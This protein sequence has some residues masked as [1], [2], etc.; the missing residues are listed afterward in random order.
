MTYKVYEHFLREYYLTRYDFAKGTSN[1]PGRPINF[2]I[3]ATSHSMLQ[4]LR[5]VQSQFWTM[6]VNS[7]KDTILQN[8]YINSTSFDSVKA[9]FR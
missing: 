9:I 3:N 2:V 7:T 8:I 4:N 6:A 1:L 5:F